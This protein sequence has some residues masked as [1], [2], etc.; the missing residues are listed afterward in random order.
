MTRTACA[1][2][3]ALF[4]PKVTVDP[5][6]LIE[7]TPSETPLAYTVNWLYAFAEAAAKLS[8]K[9]R[10]TTLPVRLP[11]LGVGSAVVIELVTA[12]DESEAATLPLRSWMVRRPPE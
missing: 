1:L 9:F 8:L 10:V 6:E 3:A 7:L 5:L 2:V 11:S 12:C 4:N